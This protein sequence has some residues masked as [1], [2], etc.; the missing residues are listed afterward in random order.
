MRTIHTYF[1]FAILL[2]LALP[3]MGQNAAKKIPVPTDS[4][5]AEA[6]KLIKEVYGDECSNAKTAV[7]KQALAKKLL[8]KA[9][10]SKD[11]LASQFVLLRL[12]RDIATQAGD[13]QTAFQA[14]DAMAETFQ[15]DVLAMKVAVLTK[16]ATAAEKPAQHKTIAEDA[17]KL[18]DGAIS[19]DNFTVADELG[20]LALAEAQNA[21]EKELVTELG[22]RGNP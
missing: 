8:G 13:R 15:V 12:T 9:N 3:V 20:K 14:I 2:A 6:T 19:L 1:T 11:D 22:K 16:L 4:A 10:E 21:S 5:R 18:V 7:E 17:L